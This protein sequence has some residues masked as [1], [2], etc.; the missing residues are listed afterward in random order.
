MQPRS[1]WFDSTLYVA[2]TQIMGHGPIWK[3]PLSPTRGKQGPI[4]HP[5]ERTEKE[6]QDENTESVQ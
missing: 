4:C 6:N 3:T 1:I 5:T 2:Y